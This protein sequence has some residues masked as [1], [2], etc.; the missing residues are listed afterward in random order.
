MWFVVSGMPSA[1]RAGMNVRHVSVFCGGVCA[2]TRNDRGQVEPVYR[3]VAS[4]VVFDSGRTSLE[5]SASSDAVAAG[6]MRQADADLREAL[7]Q[8]TFF[9]RTSLPAGLQ[10]LMRSER[11]AFLH[12]PPSQV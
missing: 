10:D 12:Q 9:V 5:E 2:R 11:P 3:T 4:L 7:P 1:I 6:G 8:V